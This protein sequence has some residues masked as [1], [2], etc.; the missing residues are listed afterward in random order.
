MLYHHKKFLFISRTQLFGH[1]KTELLI[2]TRSS[3]FVCSFSFSLWIVKIP[4]HKQITRAISSIFNINYSKFLKT[5]LYK[6]LRTGTTK[7]SFSGPTLIRLLRTPISKFPT[8]NRT[9]ILSLLPLTLSCPHIIHSQLKIIIQ[10]L[11][12][13]L[14]A[15][16]THR[17]THTVS[18]L[19]FHA[20]VSKAREAAAAAAAAAV[21][22]RH[23][24]LLI[25]F[26]R[27]RRR[28][29]RRRLFRRDER[30]AFS[31]YRDEMVGA[32]FW[33]LMDH[34]YVGDERISSL[35]ISRYTARMCVDG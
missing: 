32:N 30:P 8:K 21:A 6:F 2:Y 16:D 25:F 29:R 12:F 33:T 35:W 20:R 28:C 1:L 26:R 10:R 27:V 7:A 15:K 24:T 14:S 9:Y 19:A 17:H 3:I 5:S 4:F 23:S 13:L 11:I 31:G 18:A 22:A 34:K